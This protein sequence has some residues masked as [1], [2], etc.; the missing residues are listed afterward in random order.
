MIL[1]ALPTA[2]MLVLLEGRCELL[3][4]SKSET[5]IVRFDLI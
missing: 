3:N 5:I 1:I 4:H 2:I